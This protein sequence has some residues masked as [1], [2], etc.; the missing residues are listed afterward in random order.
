MG[1]KMV[2]TPLSDADAAAMDLEDLGPLQAP[3]GTP[4]DGEMTTAGQVLWRSEDG[5][6]RSGVWECTPG[7]MRA[8]FADDGEMVHV[9]KGT[10]HAIADDGE[11]QVLRTGD[12]AVFPPHWKGVW[13][14]GTPMRKLYCAFKA[15]DGA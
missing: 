12:T 14:L 6:V 2:I 10:I 9:V 11:E 3:V 8:D 13:A 15:G 1:R 5:S 7:R 4:L